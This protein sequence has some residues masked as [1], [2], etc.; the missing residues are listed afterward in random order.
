MTFKKR[1]FQNFLW[2]GIYYVTVFLLNVLVARTYEAEMSG[3][4][5]FISNNFAFALLIGSL[6]LESAFI[7]YGASKEIEEHKLATFAFLWSIIMGAI[8]YIF[9]TYFVNTSSSIASKELVKFAAFTYF[10]GI[11]MTNFFINL[12]L[13]KGQYLLPNII[14]SATNIILMIAIP[15]NIFSINFFERIPYLYFYYAT[16]LIQG[17]LLLAFYFLTHH[18]IQLRLPNSQEFKKIF[19][20]AFLALAANLVFFLVYRIDYWF[21]DYFRKDGVELGN[22]IQASKL[23]Q[24]LLVLATIIGGIVFPQTASGNISFVKQKLFKIF[25]LLFI[26][27][28]I[29]IAV[30]ALLGQTFFTTIFGSSFNKMFEP[31][32]LLL[33][34]IFFLSVL[35]ILSAYFGGIKRVWVNITSAALGLALIITGDYF[36]IKQYGINAAAIISTIGYLGCLVFSLYQFNKVHPFTLADLFKIRKTDFYWLKTSLQKT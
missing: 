4:I 34:G 17:I 14:L 12:F 35:T 10:L 2:R 28:I 31:L 13:I 30:T 25:R 18:T 9:L 5:N 32:L 8:F 11:I 29:T 20:Y 3:W 1:L 24:M 16:F 7:Y 19:R 27:F 36:F 26:F 23:G 6:S 33:P 22:Y 21:I 15:N